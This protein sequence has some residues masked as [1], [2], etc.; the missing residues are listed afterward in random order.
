MIPNAIQ[1]ALC[2]PKLDP[3]QFVATK[4]NTETEKAKFGD[5]LLRLIAEDFPKHLF[6]KVFYNKLYLTFGHIAHF[7]HAGFYEYFFTDRPGRIEFLDQ[8]ISYPCYGDPNFT[9]SDLEKIVAAR[10]RKSEILAWQRQLLAQETEVIERALL[11][12]LEAKYRSN[13]PLEV[14]TSPQ[15]AAESQ[16][17]VQHDL[18]GKFS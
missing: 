16:L 8:T 18:F 7:S 13:L 17:A 1:R 15:S 3:S 14:P 10:V 5:E 2:L 11:K 6:T 4:W 9:F 12:K